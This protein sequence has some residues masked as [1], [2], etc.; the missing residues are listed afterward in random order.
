MF[1]RI[2]SFVV[3]FILNVNCIGLFSNGRF[4]ILSGLILVISLFSLLQLF[5]IGYL[6][7]ILDNTKVNV[8]RA[9]YS[10]QQEVLMDRARM[11]LLIASDKLNRIWWIKRL[12]QKVVGIAS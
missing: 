12:A 2:K 9:N 10:H 1:S 5:S 4:G 3:K 8:E 11:E 6:S 7:Y